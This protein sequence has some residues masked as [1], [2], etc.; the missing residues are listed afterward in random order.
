LSVY[1]SPDLKAGVVTGII[2]GPYLLIELNY[3]LVLSGVFAKL[4]AG[5]A[6]IIP[7]VWVALGFGFVIMGGVVGFVAGLIFLEVKHR[8]PGRSVFAK[9]LV[10]AV[11]F[12][13]P[14]VLIAFLGRELLLH[15]DGLSIDLLGNLIAA[16]IF[17]VL[18]RHWS[19]E[20]SRATTTIGS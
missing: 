7:F 15:L 1:V 6:S 2:W 13:I 20:V 8:I 11:A 4:Y 3:E 18:L 19:N 9:A 5:H 17:S 16:V 10:L 12:W 14:E